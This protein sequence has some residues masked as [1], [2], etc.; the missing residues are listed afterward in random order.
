MRH[1]GETRDDL[2]HLSH[3]LCCLAQS[4]CCLGQILSHDV[5]SLFEKPAVELSGAT[6]CWIAAEQ[7]I[8]TRS[9]GDEDCHNY[10]HDDDQDSDKEIFNC[11]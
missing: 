9:G 2:C 11:N 6:A 10:T 1:V 4:L 8:Q 5:T 7:I 3:S